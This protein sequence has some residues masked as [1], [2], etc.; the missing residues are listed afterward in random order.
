MAPVSLALTLVMI[1]VACSSD[2]TAATG[3]DDASGGDPTRPEGAAL[4]DS[5]D[6]RS[7][8]ARS[9]DARSPPDAA[10]RPDAGP[11]SG[12]QT[13]ISIDSI[14]APPNGYYEYLPPYYTS[15]VP[16][17]L[18]VFWHGLGENGNG[19]YQ[20]EAGTGD[21][22]KVLANGPPTLIAANK[23]PNQRPFVV[24][25]PQ[26]G[27]GGCP[28]ADEI[29]TFLSFAV[30]HYAIDR[31]RLYLTGLSCGAIGSWDYLTKYKD[32]TVA[33]ALLI[34]GDP[35]NAWAADGCGLVSKLAIWSVHGDMDPTVSIQ[36][37]R[38]EMQQLLACPPPRADVK[39]NPVVGGGHDVWTATYDLSAG[40]GD[41]YAW[42]LAHPKPDT[43][44]VADPDYEKEIDPVVARCWRDRRR[45]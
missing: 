15:A 11:A 13:P 19:L 22:H 41:V 40:H 35:G 6:A 8:D 30:A 42:M 36:P 33:A 1:G 43:A 7:L 17:P 14:A 21:L 3:S 5:A 2:P 28:S 18:L 9:L 4:V 25:S 20:G 24:L 45:R 29:N 23:W 34:S 27:G 44:L 16:V 37:D 39:W 38:N 12:R 26:H 10:P 31:K 32:K